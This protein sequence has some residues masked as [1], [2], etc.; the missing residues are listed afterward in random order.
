MTDLVAYFN[1]RLDDM[2]DFLTSMVEHESPT[3]H[4]PS[5]D[6]LAEWLA[7]QL[8]AA[9]AQVERVPHEE[10]GDMTIARWNAEASGQPILIVSHIDTV[11]DL[12]TLDKMPI[13][14][15]DGRMYGPGTFDMKAGITGAIY[16]ARELSALDMLPERPV[17][18][19]LTSDE[20]T[21][22]VASRELIEQMA[23]ASALVLVTEPALTDGSMKTARKG[24][25]TFILRAQGVSSHAGGAH[26]EG[27]NAIV[28]MAHQIARVTEFTDYERGTT[29]SAGIVQGGSRSNVVP[30]E[31]MAEIDVRAAHPDEME[32]LTR[33][34]HDLEPVQAGVRLEISGG[35]DRLAM[36]RNELMI[37]TY[38]RAR[39][40][41]ADYGIT[42]SE[43]STGGGSDGNLTAALGIPTL[44]GL[45]PMGAGAHALHEHIVVS[46][47]AE[48]AALMA[49]ILHHWP[50]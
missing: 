42:V 24:V 12:G 16:A 43:G 28:E 45:G 34:F 22:S 49:A 17:H 2:L 21:G 20:E 46:H 3:L 4:K 31:C 18:L 5:V 23:Q 8:E 44:D 13:R 50:T 9:G 27:V 32:R 37:E 29:V 38:E 1:A 10:V 14:R 25:G 39:A 7:G 15:E 30:D 33:A 40:I 47:L 48:R 19:L 11:W 6:R 35:F 36:E 41:A 26:R